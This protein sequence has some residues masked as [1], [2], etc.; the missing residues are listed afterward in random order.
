MDDPLPK[1]RPRKL[2]RARTVAWWL[3]RS[4]RIPGTRLRF[5]LDPV[6]GLLPAGGDV[7]AAIGSGYILYV[8]WLNGAPR[9]MIG[10]MLANVLVDTLLGTVPV[11]G[12]LFDAGWQ[13]NARNVA[14]L[15]GW[16]DAEG[17]QRRHGLA[18]LVGI[19]LALAA[20][21]SGVI[22]VVW[23]TADRLFGS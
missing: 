23:W 22:G 2:G 6:L 4:F 15:E 13:A 1:R 12:D 8:A 18:L 14:M 7:V 19:V 21:L 11:L 3:D 17:P 20:L 5:G 9:G 16:L 10:R